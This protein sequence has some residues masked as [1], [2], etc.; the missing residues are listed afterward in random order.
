MLRV[1]LRPLDYTPEG[2]TIIVAVDL[3]L[4]AVGIAIWQEDAHGERQPVLFD[5]IG[6][7]E[8]EKSYSQPKLELRGAHKAFVKYKYLLVH[9]HFI[10]EIDAILLHQTL[11][12]PDLPS[13]AVTR[14]IAYI[15]QFNFDIVHVPGKKHVIPDALS[16]RPLAPDEEAEELDPDDEVGHAVNAL[17]LDPDNTRIPDQVLV[18]YPEE[19]RNLV[20][21]L[22]TGVFPPRLTAKQRS[23]ILGQSTKF[24]IYQYKFYC[25]SQGIRLEVI[26]NEET[27]ALILRLLHEE[28]GH[29]G[30]DELFRRVS[31]CFWWPCLYND[32]R[33]YV[34]L[35]DQC[36]RRIK[37]REVET[38]QP[39]SVS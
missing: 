24:F 10:L 14:W 27:C 19:W 26:F 37:T 35:C 4:V 25:R 7:N 29:R 39:T 22:E 38:H 8:T 9:T 21:F 28:L 36:Q 16:C 12:K 13:Y 5:S 3:S 20:H 34:R 33:D 23:W 18:D 15:K 31:L 6:F 1:T 2:G 17:I 30:R 11:N 32:I